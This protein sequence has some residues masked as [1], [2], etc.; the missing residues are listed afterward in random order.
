MKAQIMSGSVAVKSSSDAVTICACGKG[1][2]VRTSFL[3]AR[4]HIK[5]FV[6]SGVCTAPRVCVRGGWLRVCV[7]L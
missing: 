4:R 5:G 2:G 6:G 7:W 1:N 3:R